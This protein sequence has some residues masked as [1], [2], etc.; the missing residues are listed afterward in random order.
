MQVVYI[1]S[2]QTGCE[3]IF[4]STQFPYQTYSYSIDFG[5]ANIPQ[6]HFTRVIYIYIYLFIKLNA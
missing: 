5:V 2:K 6:K 1:S 4:F 3:C